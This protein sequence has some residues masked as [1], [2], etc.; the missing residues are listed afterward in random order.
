LIDRALQ[1]CQ[2]VSAAT[3]PRMA[4]PAVRSRSRIR[5]CSMTMLT[6][7]TCSLFA[8]NTGTQ[9]TLAAPM[10]ASTRA[11]SRSRPLWPHIDSAPRPVPCRCC[12]SCNRVGVS[13]L[14]QVPQS[15]IGWVRAASVKKTGADRFAVHTTQA[16]EAQ[17]SSRTLYHIPRATTY[18]PLL[19]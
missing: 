13:F 7:T 16:A 6:Q 5:L 11:S 10:L 4:A 3:R 14:H 19:F 18:L 15:M 12:P 2:Q 9:P 17:T 8:R 1:Q